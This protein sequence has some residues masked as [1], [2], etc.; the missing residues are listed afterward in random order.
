MYSRILIV[1]LLI[2]A[3]C[4]PK[5]I[6]EEPILDNGDRVESSD[7]TVADIREEAVERR[8]ELREE[9][10]EIAAEAL[11]DCLPWVCEALV[12]GELALG[13]NEKQ[14]L[15]ATRTTPDAWSIRDSDEAAV[16]VPV[17]LTMPPSDAVAEVVM[18]QLRDGQVTHYSYREPQ[19]IRVVSSPEDATTAGRAD[20]LAESLLRQGDELVAS[21]RF[22]A[23]LNRY[24]RARV[25]RP[26]DPMIDYRIAT[27]LDRQRRPQRALMRY[28]LFL[29]RLELEKIDA[30]GDA[31]AKFADAIA[32]A[33]ERI[34]VL[35]ERTRQS[36]Q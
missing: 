17:S 9:R 34:I 26:D 14:V 27:V 20:N 35:E 16:M 33:R 30:V 4:A 19:G 23:A 13:M 22:D 36:S 3:A 11:S 8:E 15:A 2:L 1:P 21:G 31:Y 28:Q 5:R 25:L 12:R 10:D 29:H 24:D 18:V 32:H 6:N 7:D